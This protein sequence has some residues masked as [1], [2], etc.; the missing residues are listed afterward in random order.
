MVQTIRYD[1]HA[2]QKRMRPGW[3]HSGFAEPL[4]A[5][6]RTRLPGAMR[7]PEVIAFRTRAPRRHLRHG[8]IH[9]ASRTHR[10]R[11]DVV[12]SMHYIWIGNRT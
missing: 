6:R 7:L 1:G 9:V 4:T 5:P 8:C 3:R 11:T 10:G 2:L 12:M